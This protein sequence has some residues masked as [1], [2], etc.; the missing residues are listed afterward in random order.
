[1]TII[2]PR[3]A[4]T[5]AS[6]SMSS[7]QGDVISRQSALDPSGPPE[8]QMHT[9]SSACTPSPS[10]ATDSAAHSP[11]IPVVQLMG[12]RENASSGDDQSN[13]KTKDTPTAAAEEEMDEPWYSIILFSLRL[14]VACCYQRHRRAN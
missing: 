9:V 13:T 14:L 3:E 2:P 12:E 6:G 7:R 11:L 10:A 4:P 1:M 5:V 8:A